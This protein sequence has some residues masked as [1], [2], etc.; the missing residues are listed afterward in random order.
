MMRNARNA[1]AGA[2]GQ[3]QRAG[4]ADACGLFQMVADAVF[5][6]R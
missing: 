4:A 5:T 6:K 3:V 1:L 2:S